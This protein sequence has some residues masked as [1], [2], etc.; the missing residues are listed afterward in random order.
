GFLRNEESDLDIRRRE[1]R[2]NWRAGRHPLA[3]HV[4]RVG[5]LTVAR[6]TRGFL[7]ES[8]VGLREGF[9]RGGGRRLRRADLVGTRG[10][11]RSGELSLQFAY[12]SLIAVASR[13]CRVGSLLRN[14]FRTH[15]LFL[16][17]QIALG[18]S[19]ARLGLCELGPERVVFLR[20][21]AREK[22]AVL[23]LRLAKL[24]LG[25]SPGGSLVFLL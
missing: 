23:G 12:P 1:K 17:R 5:D 10:E 13:T 18:K 6:G 3:L 24:L 22:V 16:P 7:I 8:P 15:E 14:E 4:E 9:P 21:L 25:L 19:E 20:A 11:L 2:H